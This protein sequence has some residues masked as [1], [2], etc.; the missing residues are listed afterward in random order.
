MTR[1][2]KAAVVHAFGEPLT[3][4]DVPIPEPGEGQVLVPHRG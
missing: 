4:E 3:I 1:T 2:M